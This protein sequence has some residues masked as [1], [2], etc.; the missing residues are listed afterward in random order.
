M[1][2]QKRDLVSDEEVSTIHPAWFEAIKKKTSYIRLFPDCT[3]GDG[4]APYAIGT[5][6]GCMM[7]CPIGAKTDLDL[8]ALDLEKAKEHIAK[9]EPYSVQVM[10]F[11][12]DSG[13]VIDKPLYE[14]RKIFCF[15]E[16]QLVKY[17][18]AFF[19]Y[20][21]EMM[22]M[23][24]LAYCNGKYNE[25]VTFLLGANPELDADT[26]F[27]IGQMFA[28]G[29]G[30]KKSKTVAKIWYWK[31]ADQGHTAAAKELEKLTKRQ[32]PTKGE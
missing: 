20:T 31:A 30:V 28:N 7:I 27:L 14:A 10:A 11:L 13:C 4:F 26:L 32:S 5:D 15:T 9:E 6:T 18:K 3:L 21:Q 25:A 24:K 22:R 12:L 23:G 1:K 2:E 16:R 29:R 17:A 19:S 8:A